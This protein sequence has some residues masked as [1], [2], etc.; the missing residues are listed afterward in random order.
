MDTV[1]GRDGSERQAHHGR[2]LVG[3]VAIATGLLML[4]DRLDVGEI[5][6]TSRLW[7]LAPFA[8][9]LFRLIDPPDT[10][11]RAR[12]DRGPAAW[13]LFVGCWG[14]LNEFH[15]WDLTYATSWPLVVIFVG[16]SIVWRAVEPAR[17]RVEGRH[18]L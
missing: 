2:I 15:V 3:I 12:P 17:A 11:A 8:L 10:R 4:I 5:R 13:L 7:P 9:G 1:T 14:L 18:G 6:L 16:A